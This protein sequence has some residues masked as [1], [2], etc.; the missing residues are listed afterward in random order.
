SGPGK[1]TPMWNVDG[2]GTAGNP[3]DVRARPTSAAGH[4][5]SLRLGWR[6]GHPSTQPGTVTRPA[7]TTARTPG[8]P[9]VAAPWATARRPPAP[10]GAGLDGGALEEAVRGLLHRR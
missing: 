9:A 5:G 4:P 7:R 8:A 1:D 6:A 2:N 3:G 10:G